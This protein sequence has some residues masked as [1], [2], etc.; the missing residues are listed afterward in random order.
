[1]ALA[2]GKSVIKS[3]PISLHT[4]TAIHVAEIL[5]EVSIL[6]CLDLIHL[7]QYHAFYM[8]C[9]KALLQNSFILVFIFPGE[10]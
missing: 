6:Q 1:M 3:G 7:C 2:K 10:V 8:Y 9:K 5:T 4:R